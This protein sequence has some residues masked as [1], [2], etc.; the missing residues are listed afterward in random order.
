MFKKLELN[1]APP[2]GTIIKSKQEWEDFLEQYEVWLNQINKTVKHPFRDH[3]GTGLEGSGLFCDNKGFVTVL[4]YEL[5]VGF[6]IKPFEKAQDKL[7]APLPCVI[8]TPQEASFLKAQFPNWCADHCDKESVFFFYDRY[9][10]KDPIGVF[11][12][13]DRAFPWF[14]TGTSKEL[15]PK[16]E[17]VTEFPADSLKHEEGT[18]EEVEEAKREINE[19]NKK[20]EEAEKR[21]ASLLYVPNSHIPLSEQWSYF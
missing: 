2:I 5:P 16:Y 8:R 12:S 14:I 1:P 3:T 19:L 10:L 21:L 17:T 4:D 9:H 13:K 6:E 11:F 18:V 15:K 7:P 20:L